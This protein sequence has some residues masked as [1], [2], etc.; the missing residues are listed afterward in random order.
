MT[1]VIIGLIMIVAGL[2]VLGKFIDELT[3]LNAQRRNEVEDQ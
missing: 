1:N 2:G 3:K